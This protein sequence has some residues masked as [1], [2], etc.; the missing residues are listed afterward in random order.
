MFEEAEI[1]AVLQRSFP[2]L[3]HEQRVAIVELLATAFVMQDARHWR[4]D[5]ER[6]I[7]TE[8]ILRASADL[9][10]AVIDHRRF[11]APS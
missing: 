8:A 10:R 5:G 1:V 3:D 6:F 9:L 11:L 4:S 2:H 7:R